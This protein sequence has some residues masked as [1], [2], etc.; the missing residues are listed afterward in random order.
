MVLALSACLLGVATEG[1]SI[2]RYV[3]LFSTARHS[4]SVRLSG[5]EVILFASAALVLKRLPKSGIEGIERRAVVC[6]ADERRSGF[7]CA[8]RARVKLDRVYSV[9]STF[10]NW[11]RMKSDDICLSELVDR[12]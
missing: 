12:K 9:R 6:C 4:L 1:E 2:G 11:K 10:E 8:A 7:C 5:Y 3:P